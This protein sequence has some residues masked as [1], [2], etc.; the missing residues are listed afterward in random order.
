MRKKLIC[1]LLM[2]VLAFQLGGCALLT[3]EELYCPPKRSDEYNDLQSLFDEAMR[4]CTYSAPISGENH[5]AVQNADLDGDGV[6]EYLLFAKDNSE[7]P[8]KILI[9]A[10]VASGYVLMDTIEGYGFAFDFVEYA[11]MDDRDGLEIIVGKRV[12]EDV[13]RAVSVYRFT[14]G[15]AR[16]L[17][18][19]GYTGLAVEDLDA[20]GMQELL[21]LNAGVS[22]RGNGTAVL[23]QFT[24]EMLQRTD[25][26]GMSTSI[27][28]FRQAQTGMLEDGTPAVFVT[29]TENEHSLILDVFSLSDGNL[30]NLSRG[31]QI[32]AVRNYLIFPDDIDADG[33][34][35]LPRPIALQ[36]VGT[37][38][39]EYFL[40]W[41]AFR[42]TGDGT[43][44][45]YTYHHYESGWYFFL[46]QEWL[47]NILVIQEEAGC[48]FYMKADQ[49]ADPVK[50]MT[51]YAL[52]GSDR[53][54]AATL[55]GRIALYK[56][57][58]IIYAAALTEQAED[59]GM[60][61]EYVL[62]NFYPI[63]KE[64]NTEDSGE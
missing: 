2:L 25:V 58:S 56:G 32:P 15:F 31:T 46:E 47:P 26:A 17:L 21:L 3:L 8:L 57:E 23:Y 63:R 34:V 19:T 62:K 12:S 38:A 28:G 5:Q 64:W 54:E 39:Q 14:S 52:T 16:Q 22:D 55:D 61:A 10:Q 60:T 41:Y 45:A 29:S 51:I 1:I 37:G 35:E 6:E 27:S 40:E 33:V 53:E 20:D 24:G 13:A 44:K 50:L 9:F 42:R 11:Q 30:V 7:S 49:D 59:A 4:D 36:S 48:A 43:V 18:S